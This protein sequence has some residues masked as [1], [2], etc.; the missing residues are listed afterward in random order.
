[1]Q[2]SDELGGS[3]SRAVDLGSKTFEGQGM[4]ILF[5][6]VAAL[7]FA[8]VG[9]KKKSAGGDD[10]AKA[11]GNS[12]ALSKAEMEKA[13]GMDATLMQKMADLGVQHCKDDKWSAEAT[14]CM[15]DAKTMADAQGCY[16]KLSKDQQDKMNKAA[17]DM[18]MGPHGGSDTA[19]AAG[20]A[21]TAAGSDTGAAGS[22]SAAAGS[23]ET[24]SGS[25][26]SGSAGSAAAPK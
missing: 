26:G 15:I 13:P 10:C 17:M 24:G 14:K 9:C 20:S 22:G 8:S 1:V 12:M 6:F 18:A 5:M 3:T 7:S 23:A 25:A 2:S 16:G 19:G 21:G 4:K 11:V